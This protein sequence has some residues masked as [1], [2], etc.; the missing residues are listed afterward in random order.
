ML[1]HLAPG[2]GPGTSRAGRGG[3][4][5]E[6]EKR[7]A[8]STRRAHGIG[9]AMR[10]PSESQELE[11]CAFEPVGSEPIAVGNCWNLAVD[12]RKGIHIPT[13]PHHLQKNMLLIV[14]GI[15][16]LQVDCII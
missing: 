7:I 8:K 12:Q 1:S 2:A 10:S 11:C 5:G 16:V 4:G 13:K 15:R 9:K 3:E 6:G 14:T